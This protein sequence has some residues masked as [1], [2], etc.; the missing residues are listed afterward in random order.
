MSHGFAFVFVSLLAGCLTSTAFAAQP[1]FAPPVIPPG[2]DRTMVAA[3]REDWRRHVQ[4]NF[5]KSAGKHFDVV[6]DGDS[7]TAGWNWQ[8]G[9]PAWDAHFA[10]LNAFDFGIAGDQVQNVLWRLQQGQIDGINPKLVVLLI[11]ANNITIGK[12]S[13]SDIAA[14]IKTLLAEYEKDAPGAKILL[15]GCLPQKTDKATDPIRAEVTQ[16]NDLIAP[17]A[18]GK[19]V[20][21]H[22]FGSIFLNPD[23][24]LRT[25]FFI[26]DRVHP[27]AEGYQAWADAL[28]P[29][30]EKLLA[31]SP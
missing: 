25:E 4:D 1:V 23:G 27:S 19:Q 21:Y 22:D 28:A 5:D 2:M 3:S 15:I 7:I 31:P 6:F 12:D 18:D 29:E 17:L 14:G 8:T 26:A 13:A 16:V 30:V 10:K 9:Q 24:S 20:T 11:G